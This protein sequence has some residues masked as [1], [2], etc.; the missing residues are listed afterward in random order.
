MPVI[1]GIDFDHSKV[2]VQAERQH[3][4]NC[5][6]MDRVMDRYYSFVDN[7]YAASDADKLPALYLDWG[8]ARLHGGSR[9]R[10]FLG[11][12]CECLD[13]GMS[14]HVDILDKEELHVK[15]RTK[16]SVPSDDRGNNMGGSDVSHKYRSS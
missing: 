14:G 13:C 15:Q 1:D 2:Q 16:P 3:E 5:K 8:R 11:I 10:R 4:P 6:A 7:G 9:N 12:Y